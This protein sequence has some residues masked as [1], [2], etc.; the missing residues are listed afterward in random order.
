MG[1]ALFLLDVRA[2][3]DLLSGEINLLNYCSVSDA[4][5][6]ICYRGN[7]MQVTFCNP[8]NYEIAILYLFYG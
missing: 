7:T 4:V 3:G 6:V 5:T 2:P 8:S 1:T